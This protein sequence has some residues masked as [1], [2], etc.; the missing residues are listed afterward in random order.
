M[1]FLNEQYLKAV[2]ALEAG[3]EGQG[4]VEYALIIALVA[5]ALVAGLKLLTGGISGT[6]TSITSSL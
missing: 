3:E 1:Q 4:L 5:I 2:N 6:F